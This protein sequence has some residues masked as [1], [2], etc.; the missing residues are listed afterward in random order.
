MKYKPPLISVIIPT[1]NSSLF[2]EACLFSIRDQSYQNIELIVVDNYSNDETRAIADK[3]NVRFFSKGPERSSQRNYGVRKSKGDFII[4]IDS[5]MQLSKDVVADCV[6]VFMGNSRVSSIVIPEQSFGT[7]FWSKCKAFERSFYQGVEWME[8]ARAFRKEKFWEAGGYDQSMVSGEDWY[9]SQKVQEFGVLGR[10]QSIIYHNEG[11]LRLVPLLR[12]KFYY[13][14]SLSAYSKL[15]SNKQFVASQ[16]SPVKRLSI[17]I[18][19]PRKLFEHPFIAF[20]M[21]YMLLGE[22]LI[23]ILGMKFFRSKGYRNEE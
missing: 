19:R 8:A 18:S 14:T 16:T 15:S 10:I 12:K 17:F 5:D 9:L 22:L 7:G 1:K 13:A 2:I 6:K 11:L 21:F 4:I 20:G 23:G 3:Y